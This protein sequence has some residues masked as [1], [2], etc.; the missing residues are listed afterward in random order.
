MSR[1]GSPRH[2]LFDIGSRPCFDIKNVF[3]VAA[4]WA[5]GS[6]FFSLSVKNYHSMQY[7]C[8]VRGIAYGDLGEVSLMYPKDT[9]VRKETNKQ[10]NFSAFPLDTPS[11]SPTFPTPS[12]PVL[13]ILDL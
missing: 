3:A 7:T 1:S 2:N 11:P 5:D 9:R 6:F 12:L 13:S 10:N 8:C 4:R